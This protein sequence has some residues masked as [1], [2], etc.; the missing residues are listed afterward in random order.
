ME[1]ERPADTASPPTASIPIETVS[2]RDINHK[3][4]R[5]VALDAGGQTKLTSKGHLVNTE[6]VD[7]MTDTEVEELYARYEACLGAMMTKS[8]VASLLRFMLAQHQFC[9]HFT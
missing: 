8:L 5:L 6:R 7:A 9:Y 1:G 4:A 3:R 2:S